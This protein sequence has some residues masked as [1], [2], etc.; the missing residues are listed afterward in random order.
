MDIEL[1]AMYKEVAM[2]YLKAISWYL[3]RGTKV[4]HGKISTSLV[5]VMVKIQTENFLNT[6]QILYCPGK[7]AQCTNALNKM[8]IISIVFSEVNKFSSSLCNIL[9]SPVPFSSTAIWSL[10]P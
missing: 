4:N 10:I 8:C 5:G 2:A 6:N 1:K 9:P 3:P 7:F